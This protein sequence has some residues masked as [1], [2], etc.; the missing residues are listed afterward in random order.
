MGTAE[1]LVQIP[2]LREGSWGREGEVV[3][4][5]KEQCEVSWGEGEGWGPP[6]E[7]VVV[8]VVLVQDC[9]NFLSCLSCQ[10]CGQRDLN[11][12]GTQ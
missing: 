1:R 6:V 4:A 2:N 9:Q 10:C 8:G 3:V 5:G 7:V 11:Q 12:S